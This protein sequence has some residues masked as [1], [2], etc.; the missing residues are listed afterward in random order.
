ML[1][2]GKDSGTVESDEE[3]LINKVFRLNDLRAI[4]IMKPIKDVYML[5]ASQSLAQAKERIIMSPYNRMI[6]YEGD[7]GKIVC[8]VQHR[9]LLRELAKNNHESKVA[10]WMLKPIFVN[11]MMKADV[12]MERF[13]NFHQH[14]FIVQDN[15][16]H[17][18]GVVTM[19]DVLEELFGEIYDEK[20]IAKLITTANAKSTQNQDNV[21]E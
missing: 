6:V 14:L 17:D 15:L 12:L 3:L 5:P 16:G 21:S 11:Q 7:R 8:T 2:L 1:K 9:V 13:Q 18:I 4:N 19:E 20:D 10:D